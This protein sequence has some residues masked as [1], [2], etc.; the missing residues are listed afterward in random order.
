MLIKS[1]RNL[2]PSETAAHSVVIED[3]WQNPIIVA[4]HVGGGIVYSSVGEDDF[5][6]ILKLA[7][8]DDAPAVCEITPPK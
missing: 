2:V 4:I 6:E 7:G 8:R 3:D 1:Q 5:K